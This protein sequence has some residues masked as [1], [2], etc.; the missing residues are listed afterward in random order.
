M[1]ADEDGSQGLLVGGAGEVDGGGVG[2]RALAREVVGGDQATADAIGSPV[3]QEGSVDD[4]RSIIGRR[5]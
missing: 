1:C 5:I 3:S 2:L 4:R